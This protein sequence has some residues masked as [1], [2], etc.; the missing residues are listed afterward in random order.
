MMNAATGCGH[1]ARRQTTASDAV[2]RN[3]RFFIVEPP[4]T[5][6]SGMVSPSRGR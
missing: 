5:L 2:T 6:D 4:A 3:D 1:R